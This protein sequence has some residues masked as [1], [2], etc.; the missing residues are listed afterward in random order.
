[1]VVFNK[2]TE[3]L[4]VQHFNKHLYCQSIVYYTTLFAEI[5][6]ESEIAEYNV[7]EYNVTLL[8]LQLVLLLKLLYYISWD[9][10][11]FP[12]AVP[13]EI[14]VLSLSSLSDNSDKGL[15]VPKV[16]DYRNVLQNVLKKFVFWIIKNKFI[17]FGV[18]LSLLQ[19]LT[20]S[21]YPVRY[22][23][24]LIKFYIHYEILNIFFIAWLYFFYLVDFYDFLVG[25]YLIFSILQLQT[26]DMSY[27]VLKLKTGV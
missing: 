13:Y 10:D 9:S 15:S 5:C 19:L 12:S 4:Q 3:S 17:F 27:M 14:R 6:L 7:P 11:H 21:T 20:C 23:K 1:M 24:R 18:G 22:M 25:T 8:G 16:T 26:N 2:N